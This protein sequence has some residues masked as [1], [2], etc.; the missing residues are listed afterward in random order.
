MAPPLKW[1]PALFR[2][3]SVLGS[4]IEWALIFYIWDYFPLIPIFFSIIIIEP[5]RC[6]QTAAWLDSM[7]L[8]TCRAN[9]IFQSLPQSQHTLSDL[10]TLG[11]LCHINV[12]WGANQESKKGGS[13]AWVGASVSR[14]RF[15]CINRAELPV[16]LR[17]NRLWL[18]RLAVG[19]RI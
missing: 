1:G 17:S 16:S 13:G 8:F 4:K 12:R 15:F 9:G 10:S 11:K 18:N 5:K 7:W 3:N 2:C 6:M 14:Q 19:S